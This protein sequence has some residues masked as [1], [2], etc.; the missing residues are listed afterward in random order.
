MALLKV[1]SDTLSIIIVEINIKN[2]DYIYTY[3]HVNEGMFI[4]NHVK[5]VRHTKR[6]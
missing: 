2:N 5:V 6:T 1:P 3:L 4:H